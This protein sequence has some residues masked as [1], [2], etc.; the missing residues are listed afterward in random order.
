[1]ES[2]ASAL[3]VAVT[4]RLATK[5]KALNSYFALSILNPNFLASII[6]TKNDRLAEIMTK[7]KKSPIL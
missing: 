3:A 7:E 5:A 1:M 4:I 2:N 6:Y